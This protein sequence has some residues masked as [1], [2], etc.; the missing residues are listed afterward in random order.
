M[1]VSVG[2]TA[3]LSELIVHFIYKPLSE[4]Y[5]VL[6]HE[7]NKIHLKNDFLKYMYK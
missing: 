2:L 1:F 3:L 5:V 7:L 6:E 4:H